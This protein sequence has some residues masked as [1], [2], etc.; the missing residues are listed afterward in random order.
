[1]TILYLIILFSLTYSKPNNTTTKK[2][3]TFVIET[4][5]GLHE[6]KSTEIHDGHGIKHKI[7]YPD[8]VNGGKTSSLSG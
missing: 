6:A 3:K 2:H 5:K 8:V 7:E 1:M 4:E